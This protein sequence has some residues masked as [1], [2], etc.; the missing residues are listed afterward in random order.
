MKDWIHKKGSKGQEV[1]RLQRTLG[2]LVVD[3]SYGPIT[4]AAV[5]DF[6]SANNLVVNGQ[7]GNLERQILEIEIFAGIDISKWQQNIDTIPTIKS[8]E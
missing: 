7:V 3:G 8:E 5:K 2:G 4:E 6:Q 1:R